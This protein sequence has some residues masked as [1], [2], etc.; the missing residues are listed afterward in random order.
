MARL[1]CILS[2]ALLVAHLMVGCCCACQFHGCQ[3]DPVFPAIHGA[4]TIDVGCPRCTCDHSRHGP[5]ECRGHK[6]FLVSPRRPVGGSFNL[7]LPASYAVLTDASVPRMAIRLDE[8]SQATG[9]LLP[10][11][12]LHLAN[13]VLLI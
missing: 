2:G 10:P 6:C 5:L 7:K 12:R 13:Q 8:Q 3:N 4:A 1:S 9:Y 11:I